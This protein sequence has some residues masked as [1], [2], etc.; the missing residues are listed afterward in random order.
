MTQ[1]DEIFLYHISEKYNIG[2][3]DACLQIDKC[4]QNLA[5]IYNIEY[6]EIYNKI[7]TKDNVNKVLLETIAKTRS[8]SPTRLQQSQS[9]DKQNDYIYYPP[10]GNIPRKI[11]DADL[12]NNDPD[13][14]IE[15]KLGRIEDLKSVVEIAAY[16]YHNYDGGGLNDNSF[17]ALEWHLK[18][19]EKLKGR[20]YDKIGAPP[21][22]KIAVQLEYMMP[23][24]P[25]E[26]PGSSG[27]NKFLSDMT[28]KANI[29]IKEIIG[30]AWS[31][32][33]DG[34]SGMC[35]YNNGRLVKLN[36]R[37]NGII[38]GD[39]FEVADF[40]LNIPKKIHTLGTLVVRGE[41]IMEKEVWERKYKDS[42]ANARAF[43]SGKINSGFIS[44]A[45]Q[46]VR[47]VAY[48]IMKDE[49]K[50][51]LLSKP[52][53]SFKIL[54][55]LGFEVVENGVFVNPSV[56]EIIQEY[57]SKR[58]SSK[59]KIDGLVLSQDKPYPQS[60]PISKGGN[61]KLDDIR[62]I[63][64]KM[65]LEEQI[66]ST[67]IINVEWNI[68]RYGK[69]IPVAI[70]EAIYVEGARYTRATGH[71]ARH[72]QDWNMGK[73]TKVKIVRSGDVIPQVIDVVI[74]ENIQPIFPKM[75]DDGG[76]DWHW[77]KSDIILDE[78]N[79]NKEV[80][81]KR[82]SFF[83]ETIEVPGLR[84]KT[85]E[86][87]YNAGLKNPEVIVKAEI[88][89]FIK[90]KGIGKVKAASFYNEIRRAFERIPPD[91]LMVASTTYKSGVGRKLLKQLFREIPNILSMSTEE[92]LVFFKKKKI[93][94]FGPARIDIISKGIP[95]F[96][97][98]ID[99]FASADINKSIDY[100]T[101]KLKEIDRIGYNIYINKKKFVTTG[102]M[103]KVNYD[104]EDYIY[105][106]GGDFV[107]TVT[108]DV[109]AVICGNISDI[110]K[111]MEEG[112]RLKIP[113]LTLQEF[114][115]RFGVPIRSLEE[116]KK[117]FD[118]N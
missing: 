48:K 46:D 56:F 115:E 27:L 30:C 106:N 110:K 47:F 107:E 22:E 69:Y 62:D 57:K 15:T 20:L 77:E 81:I 31:L 103:G 58:E 114:S 33:L 23:S 100:Y 50:K 86:K 21:L 102:F 1:Q 13:K 35:T 111:K 78:I 97:K 45:L 92:I 87:L 36:T 44:Q 38:G 4:I 65:M 40:F 18:K 74:D 17:D 67:K 95:E 61:L 70:Y 93:H 51:G 98:Y 94:G 37:G 99:S 5:A 60:I 42:Y 85:I 101:N 83:F 26:K 72:I 14:Y 24:L 73:G 113:V 88:S 54:E 116:K 90:V 82:A 16:L 7:F 49:S 96:R 63:A 64:F 84:E 41:F 108:S 66:R 76:Y 109:T 32:K 6:N 8:A 39:I 91:R 3:L 25:K 105:E 34:V 117:K 55:T 52:S 118:V 19:R 12:I 104:L 28:I 79:T 68:S 59:Y 89:D 53:Q 43:V 75:K 71:N 11:K 10:Y 29:G 9:S 2:L 112:Y 80:L